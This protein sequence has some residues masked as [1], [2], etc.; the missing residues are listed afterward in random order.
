MVSP[1]RSLKA[2]PKRRDVF[3]A[4]PSRPP[5][6][7][8]TI[9]QALDQ[10]KADSVV[11]LAG[12]R[13]RPWPD[14]AVSGTRLLKQITDS[15]DRCEICAFDVTYH[16]ANV[17]FEL[18]YAIARFKRIWLTLDTTIKDSA[19]NYKR[20]YTGMLAAG[21]AGYENHQGLVA[22]FLASQPWRSPEE[23]LL[24]DAYRLRVP[25]SENPTLLY[26]K[27][28][29]V[30]DAVVRA[31]ETLASSGFT[32]GI[33]L[34]D[35]RENPAATLEWY[36]E[37]I[38]DSDAVL[39]HLLADNHTAAEHNGKASFVAGL[40][41]GMRKPLL[42]LAHAPFT[43]PTDYESLLKQ[44]ETAQQC[45]T[46]LTTWLK[47]VE[48]PRRR[49]RRAAS[50]T[51]ATAPS[52]ELRNLSVGEPVAENE[53]SRLD[54]YFVETTAFYGPLESQKTILVGRRG[55]GK[56]ATFVA[57]QAAFHRDKRNH[58]CTIKPV[59]YEVDGLLRLLSED[60]QAAE[61]GFLIESLWKF[62]IYTELA[63]S[64]VKEIANRPVHQAATED[65]RRLMQYVDTHGE[66]LLAPFSQRLNRA[67]GALAGAGAFA[68]IEIQRAR[69]SEH[70]HTQHLGILRQMLGLV[71]GDRAKVAILIDNLDEPWRPASN[72][73]LLSGLLLGLL[74]ET[75]NIADDFHHGDQRQRTINVSLTTFIRSDIFAY[76][77]PLAGEQDKWPLTRIT[78]NDPELL[79]RVVDERLEQAGVAKYP[80]REVWERLFP[81]TVVG[82]PPRE[83][84]IRNTLP[85]P[86]DVIYLVKEAIAL[87]VNRGHRVVS[88]E[89]LLDA[90]E[91]YSRFVFG[92]ILAEDDPGRQKLESIL[93]EFAG[94][95]RT[96]PEADVRAR[97]A[98]AG[99]TGD[100]ADF[101]LNLLCDVNF[102]GIRTATGF[103]FPGDEGERRMLIEVARR[104]ATERAWGEMSFQVNAAFYQAL[105][106]E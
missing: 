8:E 12:L 105:Q 29:V 69:I 58:V 53:D 65:E 46:M 51:G 27:P 97:M 50:P 57:L 23:Q 101:Y 14:L 81:D 43:C 60:W 18:G 83:F 19:L 100:D 6:L 35:P 91:K 40:A 9:A 42:M 4:Y 88:P 52:L 98:R 90:R 73:A 10:L 49:A 36:A 94:A 74:R 13:F 15:I 64:V 34:D 32:D 104:L 17:A 16:N 41:H 89:D 28:P 21:Y 93:Y 68:D 75:H 30:T 38:Q 59:G 99:V 96:L 67:V 62:L 24:G 84:V 3:F 72:T 7:G 39:V 61:R 31:G 11:R 95:G 54:E 86:R 70:L 103:A 87:A 45:E 55:T 66:V 80:A 85:R 26:V 20:L 77:E 79:L 56:T 2:A 37:K 25:K 47:A 106:I 5:A 33:F 102:L 44:H 76:L 63:A 48:P 82:L 71:L 1:K 92:S 22:A 78:W